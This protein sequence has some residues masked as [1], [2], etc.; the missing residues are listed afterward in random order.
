M[1]DLKLAA[2]RP[3]E[4]GVIQGLAVE[5]LLERRLKALGFR[6]GQAV[7]LLRRGWMN[8]P[9]HVR[10]GTTEMMVRRRDALAIVLHRPTAKTSSQGF[11][12]A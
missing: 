5:V 7:K 10:I 6:P 11:E 1:T 9:L 12:A 3:G 8:G 2:L 4:S